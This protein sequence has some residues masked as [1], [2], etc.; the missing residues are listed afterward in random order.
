MGAASST[1]STAPMSFPVTKPDSVW[2]TE[3]SP[4]QFRVLREA[5]TEAPHTGEYDKH[6]PSKGVYACAGCETPLYTADQ[7]FKSGCGWPAF[8]DAIPGA[9]VRK[10]DTMFGMKR[11]EILCAACGGHLG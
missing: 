1:S 10:E 3:L 6:H 7:K 9:L 11:T 2:R 5:G 8:F 4:Q